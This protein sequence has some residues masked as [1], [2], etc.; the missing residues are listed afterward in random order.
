MDLPLVNSGLSG[1]PIATD[2]IEALLYDTNDLYN[3][4]ERKK[5][6]L[7]SSGYVEFTFPGYLTGGSYWISIKTRN[8]I[9]TWS[10]TAVPFYENTYYNFS[11]LKQFPKVQTS[12]IYFNNATQITTGGNVISS[13]GDSVVSRGVCWSTNT[14]PTT[15][16]S[17]KTSN[18]AG[19]GSFVSIINGLS[20]NTTYYFRAYATNISGTAYGN[21][22]SFTVPLGLG[23]FVDIDGNI[24][25]T[26]AIGT[27]VWMKQNL[28]VAKYRN[29]D[30]IPTGLSNTTWQ[31]ATSGAYATYNYQTV[32]D[33]IYGKLYNWYAVADPRGLCP[34]NWHVPSDQEWTT[35]ENYLGGRSVAGG[36]MKEVGLTHWASPNTGATNSSGFTGLPGGIRNN[37]GTYG[38]IGNYGFWWSATQS[39]TTNAYYRYLYPNLSSVGRQNVSKGSGFSVRCIKD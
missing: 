10:K 6:L 3:P 13:G 20:A 32:N 15:A 18:G 25:D 4:I 24:Y 23:Q 21:E 27:Q 37:V 14:K 26:I 12:S 39:S 2:S 8:A 35:L 38:L 33:S 28:K 17:T 30:S 16:L 19:I 36:K 34:T 31:S 29:G 11:G 22:V 7:S 9:E 1:N 5:S